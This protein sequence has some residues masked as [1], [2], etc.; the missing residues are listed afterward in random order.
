MSCKQKDREAFVA[1][2]VREGGSLD[3]AR[4]LMRSSATLTRLAEAECSIEVE[5]PRHLLI[6][7]RTACGDDP[8]PYNLRTTQ[9]HQ[10]VTCW[11]CKYDAVERR[12]R[13]HLA[14]GP[15]VPIFSGDPRGA[16]LRIK[17]PSGRTD[18]WGQTGICVP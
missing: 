9:N 11:G 6:G 5:H 10:L 12:V 7:A 4:W 1:T 3:L 2:M 8:Q 18:D 17:V 14:G 15:F 16:V 13:V